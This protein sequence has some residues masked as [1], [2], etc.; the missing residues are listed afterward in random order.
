[1]AV[2]E[3]VVSGGAGGAGNVNGRNVYRVKFAGNACSD[4]P[5][6][7]AWDDY[8]MSSTSIESLVGT[9]GNGQKPLVAAAHVTN[10][11][12]GGPWV[13]ELAHAGGGVMQDPN[14]VGTQHRA[15]R[16]KGNENYL[17]LGDAGDAPPLSDEYRYF[18]LAFGAAADSSVGTAGHMP[19]VSV[20]T[21]Y[22][23][24]PPVIEFAY[25]KGVDD[26]TISGVGSSWV[27]MTS[28]AKGTQMPAGIKN[29]IH[30]TG[31]GTTETSLD[32]VTKPGMGEKYAEE[33]WI[34]TQV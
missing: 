6:L 32:P 23:G 22:A 1:M 29:T 31:P 30:A 13:P 25:N 8:N 3:Q 34:Q 15:N 19:V 12:T 20:K 14:A 24:A 9:P 21:F 26:A 18:Q 17:A 5:H 16:L 28:A 7:Q 2:Y 11:R 4:I 33:Q 27:A 10:V